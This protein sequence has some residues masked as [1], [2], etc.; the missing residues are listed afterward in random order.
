MRD[1]N[2]CENHDEDVVVYKARNS[3]GKGRECPLCVAQERV[4]EQ[5]DIIAEVEEKVRDLE[6]QLKKESAQ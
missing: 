4:E 3:N 6:A 5:E 1:V 2:V